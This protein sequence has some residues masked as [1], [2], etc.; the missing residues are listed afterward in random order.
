MAKSQCLKLE[1]IVNLLRQ[2]DVLITNVKTL[3][4]AFQRSGNGQAEPLPMVQDLR[5]HKGRPR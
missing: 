4:Q 1:Q 3:A 5:Q 2:T